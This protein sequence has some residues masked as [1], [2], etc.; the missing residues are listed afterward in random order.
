MNTR[1]VPP[2]AAQAMDDQ[3]QALD[4]GLARILD[5]V[6]ALIDARNGRVPG[7]PNLRP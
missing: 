7:T 4:F 1:L 6:G 5:G 2:D 3:D